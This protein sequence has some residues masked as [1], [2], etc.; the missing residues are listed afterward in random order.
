M[1]IFNA[2]KDDFHITVCKWLNID[3]PKHSHKDVWQKSAYQNSMAA[4]TPDAFDM[5]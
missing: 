2:F 4:T 1:I 3:F 5:A